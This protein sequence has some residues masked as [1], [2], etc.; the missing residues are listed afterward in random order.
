MKWVLQ[1]NGGKHTNPQ[2][3]S[4]VPNYNETKIWAF[5]V[6]WFVQQDLRAGQREGTGME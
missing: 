5:T 4:Y 1:N 6:D 3:N 2:K